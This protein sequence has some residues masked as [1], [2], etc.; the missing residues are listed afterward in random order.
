M[1]L[2]TSQH[3][4]HGPKQIRHTTRYSPDVF[5]TSAIYTVSRSPHTEDETKEAQ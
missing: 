3:C 5:W 2:S 4:S 1:N